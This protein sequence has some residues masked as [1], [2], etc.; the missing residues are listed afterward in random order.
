ME[1]VDVVVIGAGVVGL[2]VAR[3][4]ALAGREV[5]VLEREAAIGTGTSS[6]NSEVI[7]AGIYYPQGSLKARLCVRG[8]ELLYAYCTERGIAHR[9]CGKLM[10][11]NT[12]S[13]VQGLPGILARAEANGVPDLMP[14]TRAEAR[15]LE[16]QL[17]CLAALHSPSTGIVDSHGLMLSLQGDLEHAAGLVACRSGVA[18]L[19]ATGAGV[20][21]LMQDGT[22]L[23]ARGVVNAA[24]LH[25][26]ELARNAQG[27]NPAHVPRAWYAK[28]SYFTLSGRSPFGRL[29]Y[30]VPDP[31]S[32]LAGLGVHLT[33]DLGGQAKFGPDVQWTDDPDDLSVNPGSADGFYAAVRQYWPGLPDAALVPGY[34]GMRPKISGPHEPA[35]DFRIDGPAAHGVPGLVNL[36]GIE[37][38]GLT[39]CLAI[40]EHVATLL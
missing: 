33:I 24:G 39:S 11:A 31:A 26:C 1:S 35:A 9:R 14:L 12:A 17:E 32:H 29:I 37:S 30:P 8:R 25:A 15:A 18:S 22:A 38:P 34:A 40:G 19:R 28:G 7:H 2:A 16:P 5:M 21:V 4:L 6:R 36:L 23:L 27:L 13:Q 20:E 10:V 3:S